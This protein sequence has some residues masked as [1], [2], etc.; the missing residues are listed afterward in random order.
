[1]YVIICKSTR[2]IMACSEEPL[3]VS[4]CAQCL[5]VAG[6][7]TVA[8]KPSKLDVDDKTFCEMTEEE[9]LEQL[10]PLFPGR[11]RTIH[12]AA[13]MLF[14]GHAGPECVKALKDALKISSPI[15]MKL[16]PE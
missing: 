13:E 1:M 6:T 5:E 7:F 9:K 15:M 11:A 16:M 12:D 2:L 10:E 14:Q 4:E 8:D 3:G